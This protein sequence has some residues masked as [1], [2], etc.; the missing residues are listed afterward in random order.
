M[1]AFH[2]DEAVHHLVSFVR[3]IVL[4]QR[5]KHCCE[6]P[7]YHKCMLPAIWSRRVHTYSLLVWWYFNWIWPCRHSISLPWSILLLLQ[8][9]QTP[10]PSLGGSN[11]RIWSQL[12]HFFPQ[13]TVRIT[14]IWKCQR[15]IFRDRERDCYAWAGPAS[16]FHPA[17]VLHQANGC[18][19]ARNYRIC[20]GI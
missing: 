15:R 8:C 6:W 5:A 3:T 10:W 11:I 7:W 12:C 16:L 20:E 17:I 1:L 9:L 19:C 18:S 14:T 13:C 2:R 4:I